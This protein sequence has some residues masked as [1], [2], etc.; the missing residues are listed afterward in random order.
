MVVLR[1]NP[2]NKI[3]SNAQIEKIDRYAPIE[4]PISLEFVEYLKNNHPKY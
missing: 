1:M 2:V 4:T 3:Y